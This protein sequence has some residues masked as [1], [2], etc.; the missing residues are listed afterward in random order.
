MI[1]AQGLSKAYGSFRALRDVGF[2]ARTGR[3]TGLLGHNGAGKTTCLRLL[4]GELAADSGTASVA[5]IDVLARP[6]AARAAIGYLPESAPSYPEMRVLGYLRHRAAL[7]RL[8]RSR[9]SSAVERALE[10]C[11]LGEVRTRRISELSKGYR[12]RVG[13]A[14]ALVADPAVI[15]LD[16]PASGLDPAQIVETRSLVRELAS[17]KAVLLSSHILSDVEAACDDVVVL[18][19]GRVRAAG[20]LREIAQGGRHRPTLM[21]ELRM[22]AASARALLAPIAG[23]SPIDTDADGAWVRVRFSAEEGAREAV[24]ERSRSAGVLVRELTLVSPGIERVLLDLLQPP[25]EDRDG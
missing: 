24:A 21:A 15:I 18:A 6:L 12:Q 1:E 17:E 14:A 16:E 2:V 9:R 20:A 11:W 25:P 10:R 4:T 23:E 5:G 8:A 13:L 19:R 7:A 3:V 22:D